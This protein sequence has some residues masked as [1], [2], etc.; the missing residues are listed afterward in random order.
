MSEIEE[1]NKRVALAMMK[2]ILDG[3]DPAKAAELYMGPHYRQH[4]HGVPDGREAFLDAVGKWRRDAAGGVKLDAKHVVAED[5]M[6]MV[7]HHIRDHDDP[8]D[9][10]TAVVDLWRLENGKIVEHWDVVQSIPDG[11]PRNSGPF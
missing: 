6:V 1:E 7:Y 3:A 9:R 4:A 10:G 8:S 2:T 11:D 5:D